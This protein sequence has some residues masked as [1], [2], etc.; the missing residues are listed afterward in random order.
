M[1]YQNI[2]IQ[3]QNGIYILTINREKAMNALNGQTMTEIRQFFAEDAP[4]KNDLKGVIITGAGP[5]A[6]VAGADI[7]EFLGMNAE[8]GRQ[9]SQKGQDIFL[10][11]E[12]F[13]KPVIAAVN[14]FALGGGC[15]LAMACHLRIATENA[16]FGQPEVNLG[17]IPGYGGTQRLIQYI[18]KGKAMELLL[19]GDMLGAQD[20]LQLGLVNHIAPA[21]ELIA[22][23]TS[24][25]EKIAAKGPVAIAKIIETVNAY[26]HYNTDGFNAEVLAFGATTNTEDFKE[27]AT[28]FIEKRSPNFSGK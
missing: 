5:K 16:R 24:I 2:Q 21:E 13:P 20:A 3:E 18:G 10:L 1:S 12:Q 9:L 6:F 17:I 4:K 14:G 8:K 23:A 15:E 28:A 26:F 22:K 7:K 11:I 27:G 19:T 25:I